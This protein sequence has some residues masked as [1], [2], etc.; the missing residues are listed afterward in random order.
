MWTV[1]KL[2]N[3]A[4]NFSHFNYAHYALRV[5]F[6]QTNRQSENMAEGKKHLSGKD[7]L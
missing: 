6:Q 7:E 5:I 3:Y 4:R 2:R 1:R